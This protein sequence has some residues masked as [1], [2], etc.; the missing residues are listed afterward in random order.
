MHL[1]QTSLL[2]DLGAYV[3]LTG[4]ADVRRGGSYH[5]YDGIS[6]DGSSGDGRW[7]IGGREFVLRRHV[8][9]CI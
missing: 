4:Y 3:L 1:P 8:Y 2:T 6:W 7:W 9:V 5:W